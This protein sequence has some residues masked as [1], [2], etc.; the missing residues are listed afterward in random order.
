MRLLFRFYDPTQ[1]RILINGQDLR[2]VSLESLRK[3]IGVVPQVSVQTMDE[4]DTRFRIILLLAWGQVGGIWIF[5]MT[6]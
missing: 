1:G 6:N 4:G 5:L 3:S 2:D